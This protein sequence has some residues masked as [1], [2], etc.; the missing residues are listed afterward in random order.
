V[1][2]PFPF[3]DAR[4]VFHPE[5]VSDEVAVVQLSEEADK[6]LQKAGSRELG[7]REGLYAL[8]CDALI[9]SLRKQDDS[10]GYVADQVRELRD[11]VLALRAPLHYRY[12]EQSQS[13]RARRL[14]APAQDRQLWMLK[15][16]TLEGLRRDIAD[17]RARIRAL[18]RATGG[19][20]ALT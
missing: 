20:R 16:R 2:F 17:Y 6:L 10:D 14:A 8:L 19:E 15:N 7:F 3:E 12:Y 18:R 4:A 9:Q 1:S 11:A 5:E 13:A